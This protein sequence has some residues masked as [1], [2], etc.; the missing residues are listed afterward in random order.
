MK[1]AS[2]EKLVLNFDQLGDEPV[3]YNYSFIHCNKGWQKS[4]LNP[5]DYLEGFPEN[6]IEKYD[7]SFNTKINYYHY[8][9]VFPN[10]RVNFKFSGNYIIVVYPA[11]DPD[12]PVLTRRFMVTEDVASVVVSVD[13]P[14]LNQYYKTGQQVDFTVKF[15]GLSIN[16]PYHDVSSFILKNGQWTN[17]RSDL[18]P[19]IAGNNEVI[20]NS[21]SNRNI[22]AGGN[23]FRYFDIRSITYQSEFVRKIDFIENSYHVF[24]KPSENREFKPY[25]YSQDFNGKYYIA[26]ADGR[27]MD[28]EADYLYVYFT[29]PSMYK[30]SGGKMYVSGALNNWAF[31][32]ENIMTYDPDKAEYQCTM[33]L[34]QGWYNYEYIFIKD[35]DQTGEPSLFEGNHYETEN[36]YLIL[37]YYRS[38]KERYDRLIGSALV[39]SIRKGNN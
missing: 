9:A 27:N 28:T 35:G 12:N 29:L 1:L 24:L 23:E 13:R 5:T 7:P 22:F 6:Q 4:D 11:G 19:D 14:Q 10:E 36:D 25:F 34:K 3:S 2:N 20:Y 38:V 16:D 15:T 30:I 39:N 32:D 33:L 17:I 18:S 37:V 8:S 26:V 31:N 21:L